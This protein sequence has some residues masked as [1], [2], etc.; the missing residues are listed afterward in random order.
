MLPAYMTLG[1][2]TVDVLSLPMVRASGFRGL[3]QTSD[4]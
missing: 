2:N 3:A 4:L 1:L